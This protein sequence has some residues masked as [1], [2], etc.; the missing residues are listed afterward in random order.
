MVLDNQKP[1]G[2]WTKDM[3]NEFKNWKWDAND[4]FEK[5]GAF[6]WYDMNEESKVS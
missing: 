5:E 2:D 3:L 6:E 4:W 1:K